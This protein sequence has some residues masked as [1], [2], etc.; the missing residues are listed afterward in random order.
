MVKENTKVGGKF[1]YQLVRDGA[2]IDTWE[3]ENLVPYDGLDH[4]LDVV[5]DGATAVANWYIGLYSNT[6]T[7]INSDVYAH[8]GSRFTEVNAQY[9]QATR[10]GWMPNAAGSVD[11]FHS[12]SD[13]RATFTF[14]SGATIAGAIFVSSSVKGDNSASNAV[15]LAASA[16]SPSRTVLSGDELLVKYEFQGSS[17]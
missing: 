6:Y 7:P 8:I 10:P 9:S 1:T 4:I 13:S 2:V 11:G 17:T 16:H 15:L 14:T 12:N 5:L 3:H